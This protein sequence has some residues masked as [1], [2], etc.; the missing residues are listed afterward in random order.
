M[1]PRLAHL[2]TRLYPQCWRER[3]GEELRRFFKVD[4]V[5]CVRW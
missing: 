2:L 1:N 4:E 3:Y 5:A